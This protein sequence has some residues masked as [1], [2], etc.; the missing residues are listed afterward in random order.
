MSAR[1]TIVDESAS[2]K[3]LHEFFLE[4]LGETISA[5][6][7][8]EQRVKAEVDR[9]NSG[10]R[11]GVFQGLVQP[12]DTEV[13]LNGY[14]LRQAKLLDADAQCSMALRAFESNGFLL[15]VGERQ[16]ES[17]DELIPLTAETRVSFVKLVPLVGG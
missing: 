11:T 4:L 14:A 1:I 12:T 2:G 3:V 16:I 8:I 17:L 7:V 6:Q 15:L 5:R 10:S 13:A 9:C